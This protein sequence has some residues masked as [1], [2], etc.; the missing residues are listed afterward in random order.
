M[1]REVKKDLQNIIYRTIK[2]YSIYDFEQNG[3]K[4]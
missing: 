4:S 3:S 2:D 1:T